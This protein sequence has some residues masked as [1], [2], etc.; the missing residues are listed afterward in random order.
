MFPDGIGKV[1]TAARL[2][3]AVPAQQRTQHQTIGGN[4]PEENQDRQSIGGRSHSSYQLQQTISHLI[5]HSFSPTMVGG[6][7]AEDHQLVRPCL[8]ACQFS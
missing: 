3:A 8:P 5:R 4:H 2:E 7:D 1:T 6:R